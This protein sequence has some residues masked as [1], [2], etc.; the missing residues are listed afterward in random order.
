MGHEIVFVQDERIP[1]LEQGIDPAVFDGVIGNGLFLYTPIELFTSLRY[2]QLTSAGVDRVPLDYVEAHGI[3]LHNA[4]GVYSIPMAEFALGGVLQLLKQS[5]AFACQQAR[6][7]WIKHR[8]LPELAG[9]TVCIVGC[10]RVGT[11]CA[12]RFFAMDCRVIGVD[13]VPVKKEP[14]EEIVEIV[15]LDDMLSQADIVVLTVPLTDETRRLMDADKLA[16]L[17]NTAVLV[18]IA[19]GGVVDTE[20]LIDRLPQLGGAVLDVFEEEPLPKASPL[21]ELENVI[22]T[23]HNSFEGEHNADRLAAVIRE[24][25]EHAQQ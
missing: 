2:I 23:P 12:K 10:G 16:L 1:L 14:Y 8:R 5:R 15:R 17:K 11:A 25:M 20:A 6:H 18:N 13:V 21:W 24:N 22:L 9:K 3:E 7:E 19:R 4:G